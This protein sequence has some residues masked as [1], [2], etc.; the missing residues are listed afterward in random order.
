MKKI[1]LLSIM[2][3]F[4][5]GASAESM[6]FVTRLSSP[7]GTFSQLEAVNEEL[8]SLSVPLANFGS[9]KSPSGTVNINKYIVYFKKLLL[10]NGTALQGDA[11]EVRIG[12]SADSQNG[13]VLWAHSTL[14]GK[15][16]IA[17][18]VLFPESQRPKYNQVKDTLYSRD[19]TV[20][21]AK[22]KTLSVSGKIEI[23]TQGSGDTMEWSNIYARDYSCKSDGTC[24][25]SGPT[26]T[27]YLLKSKRVCDT[28]ASNKCT[29]SGGTVSMLDCSCICPDDMVLKDGECVSKFTPKVIDIGVLVNCHYCISHYRSRC[30]SAGADPN[31]CVD[32]VSFVYS[33]IC[34]DSCKRVYQIGNTTAW[35]AQEPTVISYEFYDGG[36]YVSKYFWEGGTR[37]G[38][39]IVR[40]GGGRSTP[41][42][43]GTDYQA[44]CDANCNTND[45]S[46]SYKCLVSKSVP[47]SCSYFS[48]N[49]G[50]CHRSAINSPGTGRLLTCVR[51]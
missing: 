45:S 9:Q 22:T 6:Q 37:V 3:C 5:G 39:Q 8:D 41:N 12:S 48:Y 18:N 29:S 35:T 42:C 38:G 15:R 50:M 20:K 30:G 13:F 21:G 33:T 36:S 14:S 27:S 32:Y 31:D 10:K 17:R 11:A 1:V 51:E 24:T 43:E 47:S 28:T 46:C 34:D 16:L 2:C 26:Y 49:G 25:E 44:M 4:W 40:G 7:V 23:S 19:L